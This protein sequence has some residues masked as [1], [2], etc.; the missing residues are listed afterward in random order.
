M[1]SFCGSATWA[2]VIGGAAPPPAQ[3]PP[4]AGEKL[5]RERPCLMLPGPAGRVP[6]YSAA[7]RSVME[8]LIVLPSRVQMTAFALMAIPRVLAALFVLLLFWI[9]LKLTRPALRVCSTGGDQ[10]GRRPRR[11]R[12]GRDRRGV[13][14]PGDHRQHDRRLSHLWCSG[15]GCAGGW[16]SPGG[17][18]GVL[19]GRGHGMSQAI[20][21]PF[22]PARQRPRQRSPLVRIHGDPQ[23]TDHR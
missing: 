17:S 21:P 2:A 6:G 18:G 9:A 11:H 23:Q 7:S 13:R 19:L 8:Q 1:V 20:S 16:A 5:F 4:L 3:P 10:R 12:G 14:G 15:G 22:P